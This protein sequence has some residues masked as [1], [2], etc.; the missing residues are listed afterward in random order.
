[1]MTHRHDIIC[2]SSIDWDF[3]W[4][5]HQEIMSRLAAGGHRVLFVENTGVRQARVSDLGRIRSRI[6][7]WW[8]GTKGF[9]EERP[10]L[11]VLSPLV[12]PLPYSRIARW[13]NRQILMRSLT[14]WMRAAGFSRP[15]L[16]TFL[17]TPLAMDLIRQLEP[18][19]TIYH[20]VDEFSAS[21]AQARRIV[22]SEADL[23]RSA[24]L[25]FVTS[26][27][28]R[29]RASQYSQRV[30]LFPS[31]VSIEAF[32]GPDTLDTPADLQSLPRPIVGYVGGL[33][34]WVDQPLLDAAAA[35]LPDASFVLIGPE[36]TD[37]SVLRQRRNVH[38]LGQRPH[39]ELARYIAGFDV[40]LVPYRLAE[41]TEN[42]YPA[43]M[44]EY[45][46]MGKPVIATDLAEVRRFNEE[47]GEVIR[48][49]RDADALAAAVK[50]LA[51]PAPPEVV[52]A[53]RAVAESNGWHRRIA[54]ML[55]LIE[56]AVAARERQPS[57]W[58][59]RLRRLYAAASRRTIQALGTA[60]AL[61]L[62]LFYTPLIWWIGAPL[63]IAAPPGPADAIVVFAGGVGESGKAGV[64]FQ[65]R[66]TQ[67]VAL[68]KAGYAPRVIF[69]SG[70]VFTIREAEMMKAVA[71]DNGVPADA[72]LLEEKA[73]NTFEN[74]NYTR[75]IL[76]DNGWR[77]ILLVSSP[78]HM[79]RALWTWHNV[80]PEVSVTPTPV[81]QSDFY[82][83]SWGAS[84]DQ[85]RGILHEYAALTYY[86]VRNQL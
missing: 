15:I 22:S 10:N 85:I 38:L 12:L 4:Q 2:I 48:I 45:L 17:P 76:D 82:A 25:V 53:R 11:F 13:I 44:N 31:G 69:S 14:R 57:G 60:V 21:S 28:L 26:E 55:G 77:R 58:E 52:A 70:Y 9:R 86:W 65:E 59:E 50:E 66:V 20:C 78:Y 29:A 80:A 63:K 46:A 30:H 68:Y 64:G 41:Y 37:V 72:I 7:N 62:L 6:A 43:K 8:R 19:V 33:H 74:V 36:Q 75:R 32:T 47:H 51:V 16:W 42:V 5:G 56:S 27:K 18:T 34:Q 79:R 71:V 35:R 23:F 39:A 24:D 49:V 54:A 1:M 83:S 81:P 73:A 40:T 67:A 3:I 61:Y 84:F